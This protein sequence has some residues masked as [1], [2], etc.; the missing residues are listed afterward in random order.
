MAKEVGGLGRGRQLLVGVTWACAVFVITLV[1][2][3]VRGAGIEPGSLLL[4]V[5][6]SLVAGYVLARVTAR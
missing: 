2:D 4:R 6:F 3:A 5:P 1:S